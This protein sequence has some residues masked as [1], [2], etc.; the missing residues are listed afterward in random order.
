MEKVFVV[1]RTYIGR[2]KPRQA[3]CDIFV[4]KTEADAIDAASESMYDSWHDFWE[5]DDEERAKYPSAEEASPY[6]IFNWYVEEYGGEE[7]ITIAEE[8]VHG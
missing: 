8:I 2:G 5:T 7:A 3:F 4:G 1:K 6:Y